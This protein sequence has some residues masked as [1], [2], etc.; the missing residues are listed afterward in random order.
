MLHL[1]E[2]TVEMRDVVESYGIAYFRHLLLRMYQ[3]LASRIQTIPGNELGKSHS[4]APLEIRAERRTVH[5]DLG[6]NL[7]QRDG[8]DVMR[9]QISADLLHAPHIPLDAHRLP[10][11]RMVGRGENDRQQA[12]HFAQT[13]QFIQVVHP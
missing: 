1:P 9:H 4:L 2:D 11:K 12:E 10:R 3:Q 7:I 5:A 8:M 13:A 6:R